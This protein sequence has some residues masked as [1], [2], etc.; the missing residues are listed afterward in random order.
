MKSLTLI[1]FFQLSLF[2]QDYWIPPKIIVTS[3]G[4]LSQNLVFPK[5][6]TE[7][8][9]GDLSDFDGGFYPLFSGKFTSFRRVFALSPS[10]ANFVESEKGILVSADSKAGYRVVEQSD[11]GIAVPIP[12]LQSEGLPVTFG[13]GI[14]PSI[15]KGWTSSQ[16]VGSLEEAKKAKPLKI[17]FEIDEALKNWKKGDEYFYHRTKGISINASVSAKGLSAGVAAFIDSIW[18]VNI[19]KLEGDKFSISYMNAN[20]KGAKVYG[21]MVIAGFSLDK[22]W[23]ESQTILYTFDLSNKRIEKNVTFDSYLEEGKKK[24]IKIKEA[25]VKKAFLNALKGDLVLADMLYREKGFGVEKISVSKSKSS[26]VMRKAYFSIPILYSFDFNKGHSYVVNNSQLISENMLAEQFIGIYNRELTTGGLI[27]RQSQKEILFTGN[28]QQITPLSGTEGKLF[29]RYS[30]N[31]KYFYQR[32]K[33]DK[34][35]LELELKSLRFLIGQMKELKDLPIPEKEIGSLKIELDLLLSDM[36]TDELMDYALKVP[37]EKF[38]KEATDYLNAFFEKVPDAKE[39]SCEDRGIKLAIAC[40]S[41]LK[42]E[43]E[44]GMGIAWKYLREMAEEKKN[45]NFEK[46]VQSFAKF[47]EAMASNRFTLKTILRLVKYD[48]IYSPEGEFIR[49]SEKMRKTKSGKMIR[50]PY[51]MHFSMEGTNLAPYKRILYKAP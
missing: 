48:N 35:K 26:A 41:S 6:Q 13:I 8:D 51:E 23:G 25:S 19:D 11:L 20:Q 9:I 43:T 32:N 30:A 44:N 31:F 3:D 40:V 17:P 33:V 14:T 38:T 12:L 21:S 15:G 34:K 45:A 29:R 4:R 24:E 46:F 47:G 22:V 18:N 1:L 37:K 49:P 7:E 2:A 42:S 16:V 39:E 36:A 50:I 27:S 28:F 10:S 5:I